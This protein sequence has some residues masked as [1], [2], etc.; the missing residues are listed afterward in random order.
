[1]NAIIWALVVF[2]VHFVGLIIYLL[3]R[4][5]HRVQ[6]RDTT[7]TGAAPAGSSTTATR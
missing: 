4:T 3:V 1:M 2:F 7:T 5:E 6:T